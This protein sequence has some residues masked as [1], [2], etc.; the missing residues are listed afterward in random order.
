RFLTTPGRKVQ[1]LA[2]SS[3][4]AW[5]KLY[6]RDANSDNNQISYYL[7][8]ELVSLLLDLLIRHKHN[9]ER[10][11]DDVMR[12]L[13]EEFGKSEI[14]YTEEQLKS[15]LET[16][17][18][19][20]LT[21]FLNTYLHTTTELPLADYLQPFGLQIQP[22]LEDEATPYLGIR[23][24]QEN[25]VTMIKFVDAESPA[26]IMGIDA[27]DELLAIDGIRVNGDQLS[28]RLKEYQAGD[29][30]TVTIFHQDELLTC[31]VTLASPQP[32]NYKITSI[33]EP[34]QEQKELLFG[35]LG[36]ATV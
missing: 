22:T 7:K 16:V 25:G 21:E 34:S 24:A 9:N 13:W 32:S 27:G 12:S 28:D 35:W 33:N 5:I 8:G 11:M 17:A 23:V 36:V 19:T 15:V 31:T 2:E 18:D 3:F 30:I 14:G 6:R 20:D 4:D 1:P 10:S 26:G 29:T